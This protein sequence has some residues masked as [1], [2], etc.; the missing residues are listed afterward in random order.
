M[1]E[2]LL[3]NEQIASCY[4]TPDGIIDPSGTSNPNGSIAS[5]EGITSPDGRILGK[6]G[7]N[8]RV[9]PGLY[10]NIPGIEQQDIFKNGVDYF[11]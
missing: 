6:M 9:R 8:E 10:K 3:D 2:Q 1:L 4:S 5:I 11:S 7:H